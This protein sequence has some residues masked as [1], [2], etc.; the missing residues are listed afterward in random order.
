MLRRICRMRADAL[1]KSCAVSSSLMRSMNV[2][3]GALA[4]SF[5]KPRPTC[6][7]CGAL[8]KR[9]QECNVSATRCDQNVCKVF[10]SE[11]RELVHDDADERLLHPV[12][13]FGVSLSDHQLEILEKHPAERSHCPLVHVD[14]EAD[15][16]NQLLLDDFVERLSSSS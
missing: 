16:Q 11:G 5:R 13:S 12:L 10:V 14:I 6:R 15:I 2:V 1:R 9:E 7:S 8:C 4:T 3:F